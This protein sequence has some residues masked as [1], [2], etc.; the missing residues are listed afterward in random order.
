MIAAHMGI[1]LGGDHAGVT[2]QLLDRAQVG[3]ILEQMGGEA[4]SQGMGREFP[5][6]TGFGGYSFNQSPDMTAAEAIAPVIE[7]ECLYL[8]GCRFRSV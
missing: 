6:D 1:E 4:V 3:T 2:E 5:G 7:K 8:S